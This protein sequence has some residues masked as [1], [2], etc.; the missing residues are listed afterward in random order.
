MPQPTLSLTS[1]CC[2]RL[3][4]TLTNGVNFPSSTCPFLPDINHVKKHT[5]ITCTPNMT[6]TPTMKRKI[7]RLSS[8]YTSTACFADKEEQVSSQRV[9]SA[10]E[11]LQCEFLQPRL[12]S[13]CLGFSFNPCITTQPFPSSYVITFQA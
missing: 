10:E 12:S 11:R 1:V 7:P 5:E 13:V 3:L 4:I 6:A 9:S 2:K 8:I